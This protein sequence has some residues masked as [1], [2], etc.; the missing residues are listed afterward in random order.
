MLEL[1][2]IKFNLILS[3]RAILKLGKLRDLGELGD[4]REK[5]LLPLARAPLARAP[6]A[7]SPT[8]YYD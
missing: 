4:L 7:P 5:Y 1:I 2:L 3:D 8:P 6:L